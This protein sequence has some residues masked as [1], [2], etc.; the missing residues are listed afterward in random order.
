MESTFAIVVLIT[1]VSTAVAAVLT[2]FCRKLTLVDIPNERSSH[3]LP[4]PRG[5]GVAIVTT[6]S[7]GLAIVAWLDYLDMGLAVGLL[8]G[9]A[10]VAIAGF[11]DDYR[12]L[13]ARIRLLVHAAAAV[14]VLYLMDGIP[15]LQVGGGQVELSGAWFVVAVVA[16]VWVLNL[17]N[18]MDG[19]DGIAASEATFVLLAGGLLSIAMGVSS[20]IAMAAGV[21]AG[22]CVGFLVWNWPPAKIFMGDV[23]SGYIGFAIA[24]LVVAAAVENPVMIPVWLVLGAPFF[25]DATVTLVRRLLRGEPVHEAH[26]IH[27]YQWLARRW[28]SHRRVTVGLSVINMAILLPVAVWCALQPERS[29]FILGAVIVLFAVAALFAGAG[30]AERL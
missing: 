21:L 23:G 25:V 5:G 12:G 9:G 19:I 18:F 13:S 29:I 16:M 11:L 3:S 27:A 24:V 7:I 28:G 8:V 15:R 10:G 1:L 22:S 26:R 4:T 14:L 20:G 6:S 30:K 2:G 17:F